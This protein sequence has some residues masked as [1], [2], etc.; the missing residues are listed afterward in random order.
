MLDATPRIRLQRLAL[1]F[2]TAEGVLHLLTLVNRRAAYSFH[3]LAGGLWDSH[4]QLRQDLAPSPVELG[5]ISP[6]V[7]VATDDSVQ[8]ALPEA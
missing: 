6:R 4:W 5:G 1:L 8:L 3:F 7:M 2:A